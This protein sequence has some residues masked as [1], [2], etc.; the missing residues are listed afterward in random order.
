MQTFKKRISTGLC[1]AALTLGFSSQSHAQF[2]SMA[3]FLATASPAA[4]VAAG[5]VTVVVLGSV[6]QVV[7][8]EDGEFVTTPLPPTTTPVTTPTTTAN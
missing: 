3:E 4:L 5:V 8:N 6:V 7:Q 2:E 1:V